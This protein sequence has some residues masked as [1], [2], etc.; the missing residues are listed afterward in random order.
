MGYRS[1]IGLTLK[2]AAVDLLQEMLN[3]PS[4]RQ[5]TREAAKDF[6]EHPVKF[7]SKD[8]C[9]AYYWD[10]VKWYSGDVAYYPEI[11][12]MDKFLEEADVKDYYFIRIGENYEDI[13]QR[14]QDF[15]NVFAMYPV[16]NIVFDACSEN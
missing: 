10:W 6:L 16:C 15:D 8:G 2:P 4:I 13:E 11:W 1:E 14:G 12:F 7:F 9:K 3:D 5:E